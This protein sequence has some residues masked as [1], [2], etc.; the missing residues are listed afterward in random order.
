MDITPYL[1]FNGQCEKAFRFYERAL[2]GKID[3]MMTYGDSPMASQTTPDQQGRIMHATLKVGERRIQ[4]A[5]TPAQQF[6]KPQGFCI[7]LSVDSPEEAERVFSAL[8]EGAQ[9]QM[10]LQQT[11]WSPRFGML[12]DQFGQP[13]MVNTQS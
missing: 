6:S 2:N 12:T 3:F 11:F 5:D 1:A 8:S 10:P 9:V 7:A 13:W 4:G